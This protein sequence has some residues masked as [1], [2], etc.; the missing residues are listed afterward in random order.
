MLKMLG[1]TAILL[2]LGLVVLGVMALYVV[3]TQHHPMPEDPLRVTVVKDVVLPWESAELRV[4]YSGAEGAIDN[5]LPV[6]DTLVFL[7]DTSSSMVGLVDGAARAIV[8][9][10]RNLSAATQPPRIGVMEFASSPNLLIPITADM[11]RL[12]SELAGLNPTASGGTAFLPALDAVLTLLEADGSTGTVVLLTDAGANESPAELA[13]YFDTRWRPAGH[14][15]FMVGIGEGAAKAPTLSALTDDPGRYILASADASIIDQLFQEV[16][17]RIGNG[18]GRNVRLRLPMAEPLWRWDA[19]LS[20]PMDAPWA[21]LAPPATGDEIRITALF[22]RPYEWRIA[23]APRFGGIL[24]TLLEPASLRYGG[25]DGRTYRVDA[26]PHGVPKVLVLTW[27]FLFWFALPAFIYLLA[28][29]IARLFRERIPVPEVSPA[30]WRPEYRPP[31]NLPLRFAPQSERIDWSPTLII[32]LGRT[33]RAVLTHLKQNLDDSF[34]LPSGRPVL[35]ALDVARDEL[36]PD[37]GGEAFPGCLQRLSPDQVFVLPPSSCALQDSIRDQQQRAYHD[38]DDPAAALDLAPYANMG[39][40]ALRLIRGSGGNPPLARLALLND[41]ADGGNSALLNKLMKALQDWRRV[42]PAER[43]R[44]VLMVANVGGGV[45]SGWLTDLLILLRRLVTADEQQGRAVEINVLLLGDGQVRDNAAVVPLTAPRLFAELDRL[46][47]AGVRPFRHRLAVV[48][49]RANA[50]DP[51]EPASLLD[52]Q[53]TRRP[54]DGIF[55]LPR[56]QLPGGDGDTWPVAADLLTLLLDRRRRA[57]VAFQLQ[58]QKGVENA[59]R[60]DHGRELYTEMAIHNA[61]FPRGFFRELLRHR[62][63]NLIGHH[64]VLFPE[65]SLETGRPRFTRLRPEPALLLPE[66]PDASAQGGAIAAVRLVFTGQGTGPDSAM[67]DADA[68]VEACQ[69]LRVVLTQTTT[70]ALQQRTIGLLGLAEVL[71]EIGSRLAERAATL[72]N[73]TVLAGL[74]D[75]LDI[76]RRQALVWVELFF[77]SAVLTNAGFGTELSEQNGL[78]D[79]HSSAEDKV[80]TELQAWTHAPSRLLVGPP[81]TG[82]LAAAPDRDR[83]LNLLL[84]RFLRDWL[85]IGDGELVPALAERCCWELSLP[86][87]DGASLGVTLVLRGTRALRFAPS[88]SEVSRFEQELSVQTEPTFDSATDFHVLSLLADSLPHGDDA[89]IDTFV[90]RLKGTLRGDRI[91]LLATLPDLAQVPGPKL[92]ALR[93]RLAMT[94]E[95]TKAN[96]AER[97]NVASVPD[98]SRISLLQTMPML[99]AKAAIDVEPALHAPE[100]RL[101]RESE[102]LATALRLHRADLPP[103]LGIALEQ[104]Q[105][106]IMF[107]RLYRN[108]QVGRSELDHLWYA[109]DVAAQVRLTQRP[110]QTLADAAAYFA[111]HPVGVDIEAT[112]FG[113]PPAA[114]T[115]GHLLDYLNRLAAV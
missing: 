3:I 112:E 7:L 28:E 50:D 68:L 108:G 104:R 105:R 75:D 71:G 9:M 22:A 98:R 23:L 31:P 55:V 84:E 90:R 6:P 89:A 15:L 80:I 102:Q 16:A 81:G 99:T 83:V 85:A 91:P 114:E 26:A 107:A 51:S 29:L 41:L 96:A 52:G 74:A 62:L 86:G 101:R 73:G 63:I 35:L 59:R 115:E 24:R 13:D 76:A 113:A 97:V 44:Q 95:Q 39:A 32:G 46:A 1:R 66:E 30:Q 19:T 67:A 36:A 93:A 109:R 72:G 87:S 8:D 57:L 60:A 100:R 12:A 21:S 42:L 20:K 25:L 110:S 47:A 49:E 70:H 65:R 79:E 56:Y 111:T 14:E 2:C 43:N 54:Q 45:G 48:P 53:V 92:H 106:L 82:E 10:Q 38:P 17:L 40:D 4:D 27:T 78:L 58:A 33:G 18:I 77:G 94:L 61:V 34:D 37:G 64:Q 69:R 88:L 11:K 103:V 5:A